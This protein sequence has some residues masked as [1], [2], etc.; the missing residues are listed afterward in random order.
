MYATQKPA[1]KFPQDFTYFCRTD[2]DDSCVFVRR[3]SPIKDIKALVGG[4]RSASR[5]TSRSAGFRIRR[6]SA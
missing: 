3:D 1:Y 6:P 4:R 2:I 5:S